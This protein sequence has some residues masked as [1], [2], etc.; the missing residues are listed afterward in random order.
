MPQAGANRERRRILF[1]GPLPMLLSG[2][3][4]RPAAFM[5]CIDAGQSGRRAAR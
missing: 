3:R 4:R 2:E 5:W 1:R